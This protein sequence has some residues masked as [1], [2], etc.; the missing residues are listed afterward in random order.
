MKRT[1]L[2]G[3]LLLCVGSFAGA[4]CGD[5]S[6]NAKDAT[7]DKTQRRDASTDSTFDGQT[8]DA[9]RDGL[10][11]EGQVDGRAEG[12]IE[13]FDG[14]DGSG[15]TI[16]DTGVDA[17]ADASPDTTADASA[18][19]TNDAPDATADSTADAADDAP[20]ASVDSTDDATDATVD[21]TTDASRDFPA[22]P[23][24]FY[25]ADWTSAT[26]GA[27][28]TAS[29]TIQPPS[30]TIQVSYAGEIAGAQTSGGTNYWNPGAPYI[31]VLTQNAPP[32]AD[33]I[34]LVGP[35]TG[36]TI[37]F[38]P[39]VKDLVMAIVSLGNTSNPVTYTFNTPFTLLS[40]GA[41]YWGNGTITQTSPTS[42][43][44][45][46]G[47]GAIVFHGTVSQL[48]WSV[49][50]GENWHGFTVGIPTQ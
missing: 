49:N 9:T 34:R 6:G 12:P 44:G 11:G 7:V 26:S 35:S 38:N 43:Y 21:T 19:A 37:T 47:H 40:F 39:P 2:L 28:G 41:G 42:L 27:S 32:A 24:T 45:A 33:I 10:F 13:R 14:G 36:N 50:P 23:V 3:V 17:P 18:D 31:N 1:W 4:G 48:T 22:N 46:E 20:D 29:A 16:A 15:E 30:G 5:S 25:W 8:G